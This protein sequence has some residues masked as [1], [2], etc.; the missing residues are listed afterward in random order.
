[1]YVPLLFEKKKIRNA[2]GR[3]W[4]MDRSRQLPQIIA[5]LHWNRGLLERMI[6]QRSQEGFREYRQEEAC[7]TPMEYEWEGSA[8][9]RCAACYVK[10]LQSFMVY[11]QE[12][13]CLH[14]EAMQIL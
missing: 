2:Y 10:I 11:T 6:L 9:S 5:A 3:H 1:M 7:C 8:R 14:R 12:K 4:Q 13:V